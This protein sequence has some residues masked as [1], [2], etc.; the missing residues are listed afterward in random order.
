MKKNKLLKKHKIKKTYGFWR[1]GYFKKG[2]Q[3]PKKLIFIGFFSLF[4]L[5]RLIKINFSKKDN[6]LKKFKKRKRK[7]VNRVLGKKHFILNSLVFKDVLIK[8]LEFSKLADKNVLLWLYK[9]KPLNPKFN[10]ENNISFVSILHKSFTYKIIKH[11]LLSQKQQFNTKLKYVKHFYNFSRTFYSRY[12]FMNFM[13]EN[14][15]IRSNVL[16]NVPIKNPRVVKFNFRVIGFENFV[17]E[18]KGSMN[19]KNSFKLHKKFIYKNIKKS[20]FV[21]KIKNFRWLQTHLNFILDVKA[22]LYYPRFMFFE[23]KYLQKLSFFKTIFKEY[24]LAK[25]LFNIRNN[26]RWVKFFNIFNPKHYIRF[27]N[28]YK[29]NKAQKLN[30]TQFN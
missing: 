3:L 14:K 4:F 12:L 20:F 18:T 9:S 24:W 27:F 10:I 25:Q 5:F 19:Y 7:L 29:L 28:N 2:V 11:N 23:K 8:L 21:L 13:V 1:S 22:T 17:R 15:Q 6:I 30:S 26:H 16:Y